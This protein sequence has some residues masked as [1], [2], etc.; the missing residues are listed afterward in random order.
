[1]TATGAT[2]ASPGR[3]AVVVV[4]ALVAV[5]AIVASPAM[6]WLRGYALYHGRIEMKGRIAGQSFDLPPHA[7]RCAG[8]HDEGPRQLSRNSELSLDLRRLNEPRT[9]RGGPAS[10]YT[11]GSFCEVL[12]TGVDASSVLLARVMP[13]FSA[14]DEDC[15][16]LWVY[17]VGMI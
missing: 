14:R 16:A 5:V 4:V 15:R 17:L 1:M 10:A 9:R 2:A 7:L 12:R 8:C 13:R 11:A 3:L 6:D